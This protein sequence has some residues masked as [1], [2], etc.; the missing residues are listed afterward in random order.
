MTRKLIDWFLR[1]V[2]IDKFGCRLIRNCTGGMPSGLGA[3]L[4]YADLLMNYLKH[5]TDV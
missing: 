3:I 1:A 5:Q 4:F 2:K